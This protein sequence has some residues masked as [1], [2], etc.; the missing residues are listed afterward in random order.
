MPAD[1]PPHRGKQPQVGIDG[2]ALTH[3]MKR[4]PPR[5]WHP[6]L[7]LRWVGTT[8]KGEISDGEQ[9]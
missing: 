3:I 9:I 1:R 8:A 5:A 6:E 7:A 2:F 4:K